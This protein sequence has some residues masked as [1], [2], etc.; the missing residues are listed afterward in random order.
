MTVIFVE[1]SAETPPE[2]SRILNDA[3]T[4]LRISGLHGVRIVHRYLVDGVSDELLD[5]AASLVFAD[6]ASDRLRSEGSVSDGGELKGDASASVELDPTELAFAVA[7]LPGQFDSRAQAAVDAL[8]V[9]GAEHPRVLTA[10]I[11]ILRGSLSPEELTRVK[12]YL[13]NPV[14]S[15]ELDPWDA[16]EQWR[17]GRRGCDSADEAADTERV[18]LRHLAADGPDARDHAERLGH[19]LGLAMTPDDLIFCARSFRELGRE[20]RI[21]ELRILDTYW[22]DHCRHQTFTTK[23]CGMRAA[24]DS[25]EA[26]A[27]ARYRALRREL[28]YG[29]DRPETLMDMAT[30]GAKVLRRRGLLEDLDVSAEVN[31]AGVVIDGPEPWLLLF[32]NETHN[33]PTEIEP[34][35][36]AST[37]IGG[38]I[39]DPMS[40]RGTVFQAIRV[41]GG[42]D[43]RTAVEE[44]R[45]GKLPQRRLAVEAARGFSSYG[46]QFGLAT[47]LVGEHYHPGFMAKRLEAG[48]VVGAVPLAR[49]RREQPAPGDVVLL[50]GGR[51]GRDGIGGATG[52]SKEHSEDSV[53][54]AGAEVQKGN[55]PVERALYRLF[56]R[57]DALS[58]IKRCNDFGAGGVAVAVGELA[59]GMEID[60][61]A[62]PRKYAHLRPEEVAL[63][64]SQERMAVVIHPDQI[65]AFQALARQENLEATAIAHVTGSDRLV[66]SAGGRVAELPRSLLDAAGAPKATDVA[67]SPTDER[68]AYPV[69]VPAA[70]GWA[71]PAAWI[72]W[73]SRLNRGARRGLTER[74]DSSIGRASVLLPFGGVLQRTPVQATVMRLPQIDDHAGAASPVSVATYG[75]CPDIAAESPYRGGYLAV[76]EALCRAVAAGADPAG[77]RLSLQEYFPRPGTDP[78]RWGVPA[79]ALLGALDAQMDLEVPAI[80]GKDSMSGSFEELDVPPTLIAFAVAAS[81]E[82]RVR[83]PELKEPGND[84]MLL[85]PS[86]PTDPAALRCVLKLL[87]DS[88]ESPAGLLSVTALGED[89]L[90]AGLARA[91]FGNHIGVE[92]EEETSGLDWFNPRFGSFLLEVTPDFRETAVASLDASRLGR[93]ELIRLGV[94]GGSDIATPNWR[95]DLDEA[96]AAWHGTL[97]ELFVAGWSGAGSSLRRGL[98]GEGNPSRDDAA[99]APRAERITRAPRVVIPVF[100]GTNCEYDTA[101]AVREAGGRPE[102]LVLRTLDRESMA[103]SLAELAR[104]IDQ[105]RM[106][107]LPGGFSAGDE[108]DGSGK[109]MAAVL[110][111]ARL[112]GAITALL[113]ERDG[114]VLGICNGFQALVR[115]GLLPSG[116]ISERRSGDPLLAENRIGHHVARMAWVRVESAASPWLAATSRGQVYGV[117]VS[118]GEGRFLMDLNAAQDLLH[119]G[120]LATRYVDPSGTLAEQEPWNPN[121]SLLSVEGITSPDGRIFGKMGHI[122]RVAPGLFRNHPDPGDPRIIESGIRYVR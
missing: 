53:A 121:G 59:D 40:G 10:R 57:S 109:F 38:A 78:E 4:V 54:R 100:P 70:Q 112:A 83:S 41:S 74:F 28:G 63:S 37:C 49:V 119:S 97:D 35:G 92:L 106:L 116:A 29:E 61:D 58:L 33:H 15:Y 113:E 91:C 64:E 122:E 8:Q 108:P 107:I 2:A 93:I 17:H 76:T 34:Y 102:T 85:A 75:F 80:G 44:T 86:P 1:R 45:A 94:T 32:K 89:G 67:I 72:D 31:A 77:V 26:A 39:R 69:A 55:P 81:T 104:S 36:G 20:P 82:G 43:P 12:G 68:G 23:L 60:L 6:P 120:R 87:H 27:L 88:A 62:V 5:R 56:R 18:A 66:M 103:A 46:N 7:F 99:P 110:R 71:D 16:R 14:D 118:H 52:S 101:R 19:D 51:T 115:L 65:E 79:A 117:P 3:R 50:V 95:L 22:S 13:V 11:I 96:F 25:T 111:Q 98:S 105:S 9:L 21:T 42:A 84:L 90:A 30:I 24:P 48:A 73:L 47:G 114:L